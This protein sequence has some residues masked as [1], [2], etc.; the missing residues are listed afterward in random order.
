MFTYATLGHGTIF[1]NGDDSIAFLISDMT[2]AGP[3]KLQA[4]AITI[5][6]RFDLQLAADDESGE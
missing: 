4:N 1:L 2:R 3:T 5:A 6:L